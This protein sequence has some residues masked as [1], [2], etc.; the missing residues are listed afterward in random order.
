ME[1]TIRPENY[2]ERETYELFLDFEKFQYRL[3]VFV[4]LLY[5]FTRAEHHTEKEH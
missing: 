5:N 1:K 3:K 2:A 4:I